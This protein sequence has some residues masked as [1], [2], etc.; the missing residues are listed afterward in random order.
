[1]VVP[2]VNS[3]LLEMVRSPGIAQ[4]L[5]VFAATLGD[6]SDSET[7]IPGSHRGKAQVLGCG[8][9]F[10]PKLGVQDAVGRIYATG[11]IAHP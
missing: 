8:S 5:I 7:S 2:A 3:R 11:H 4:K 1:M 9:R 10:Q 6:F